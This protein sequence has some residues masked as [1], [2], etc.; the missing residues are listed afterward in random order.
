MLSKHLC[1]NYEK[2][3]KVKIKA[4]LSVNLFCKINESERHTS[5][6]LHIG[7][8][9]FIFSSIFNEIKQRIKKKKILNI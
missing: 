3:Q 2:E 5:L 9:S 4:E 8:K 7:I 6:V 1:K